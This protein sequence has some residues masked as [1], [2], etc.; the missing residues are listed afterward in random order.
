MP[1][2]DYGWEKL[3]AKRTLKVAEFNYRNFGVFIS[4]YSV[5]ICANADFLFAYVADSLLYLSC[6]FSAA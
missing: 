6:L 2:E 3:T 4:K 5:V 1:N